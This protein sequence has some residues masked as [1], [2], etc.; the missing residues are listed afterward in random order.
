MK[1]KQARREAGN[2]TEL[3]IEV[4]ISTYKTSRS[5]SAGEKG[6]KGTGEGR[7][8]KESNKAFGIHP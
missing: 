5:I 3:P 6:K 1:R 2:A 4:V 8:K 7:G